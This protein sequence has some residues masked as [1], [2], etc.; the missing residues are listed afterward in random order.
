MRVVLVRD[1]RMLLRVQKLRKHVKD[2]SLAWLTL[3]RPCSGMMLC[4]AGEDPGRLKATTRNAM[5]RSVAPAVLMEDERNRV[6]E[7]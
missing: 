4:Y 6:G 7:T 2:R 5:R 3:S 1:L